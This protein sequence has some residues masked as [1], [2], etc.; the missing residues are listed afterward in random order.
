MTSLPQTHPR[1]I[2]AQESRRRTPQ[3]A[4]Q[5]APSSNG[6]APDRARESLPA[7]DPSCVFGCVDWYLYPDQTAGR[8]AIE[9]R[10]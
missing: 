5:G 3:A 2:P 4:A 8:S 1:S 6:A 7:V 9:R 10:A